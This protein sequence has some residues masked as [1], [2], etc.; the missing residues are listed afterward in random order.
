MSRFADL[1]ADGGG[2]EGAN[3]VP[4]RSGWHTGARKKGRTARTR[5]CKRLMNRG[6]A[7]QEIFFV[8]V[9]DKGFISFA[10][11][12]LEQEDEAGGRESDETV[13]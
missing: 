13:Q 8:G 2:S 7:K 4:L 5:S 10:A 3:L 12:K 9:N 11:E 1:P 6:L